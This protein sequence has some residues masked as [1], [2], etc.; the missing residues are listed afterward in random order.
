MHRQR[1][2]QERPNLIYNAGDCGAAIQNRPSIQQ[3]EVFPCTFV[4]CEP[5]PP[6]VDGGRS[7]NGKRRS[8]LVRSLLSMKSVLVSGALAR[9]LTL[10]AASPEDQQLSLLERTLVN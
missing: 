10:C 9:L 2:R 5:R 4:R 7:T 8:A 3:T 1:R 6:M